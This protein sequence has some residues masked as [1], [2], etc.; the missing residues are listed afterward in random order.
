MINVII[1]QKIY[2]N[3]AHNFDHGTLVTSSVDL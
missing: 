3:F 2:L 1:H